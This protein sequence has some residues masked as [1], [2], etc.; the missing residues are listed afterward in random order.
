MINTLTDLLTSGD[1]ILRIEAV[2]S[3][4]LSFIFNTFKEDTRFSDIVKEAMQR[5]YT[6]PDPRIDLSGK[7]SRENF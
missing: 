7:T 1:R 3:G 5:G 2:L 4:T 6:E